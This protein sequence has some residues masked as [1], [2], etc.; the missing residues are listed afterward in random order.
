[1]YEWRTGLLEVSKIVSDEA[2]DVL[3]GL[4]TFLVNVRVPPNLEKI[5]VPNVRRIRHLRIIARPWELI[6]PEFPMFDPLDW[7]PL[8]EGLQKFC[9]VTQMPLADRDD[10]IDPKLQGYLGEWTTWL[11]PI[12]KYFSTNLPKTTV[13]SVDDDGHVET[14]AMMDKHFGFGYQR[15][16]T[17]TGDFYF[18]RGGGYTASLF[19]DTLCF[20]E[21]YFEDD[22]MSDDQHDD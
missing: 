4:N 3:Y 19:W 2:L 8:L 17:T 12:L 22:E 1:M 6:W 15:V 5:D 7:P 13:V 18:G 10:N 16:R 14:R 9:I 21:G 11:D 20:E